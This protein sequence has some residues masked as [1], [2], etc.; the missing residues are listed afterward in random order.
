MTSVD[1]SARRRF[2]IRQLGIAVFVF[3]PIGGGVGYLV[4]RALRKA[5][6][7]GVPLSWTAV[8]GIS[9]LIAALLIVS[10]AVV[11]FAATSNRRW[12]SIVE[13]QP[14]DEPVDPAAR[15]GG[16]WQALVCILAA[17]MMI[18]PPVAAHAGLSVET[19]VAIAGSIGLL[20]AVQTWLNLK[21]WR[22]GDELTRAVIA[23]T[24]ALCFWSLQLALFGWAALA[25]LD[26]VADIDSWTMFTVLMGAYLVASLVISQRR[27]LTPG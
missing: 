25:K 21:L 5:T 14:R 9:L 17:G 23:Q 8:E 1:P 3:A 4:G 22:D 18:L 26:L 15:T 27:G 12:N 24:G 13:R 19:R 10:G 2:G 20:L 16:L 7:A 11:A 6:P